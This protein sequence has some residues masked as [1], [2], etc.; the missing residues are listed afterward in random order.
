MTEDE[1]FMQA[2]FDDPAD[3]TPR[4]V[5]AD[6]LEEQ[7]DPRGQYLRAESKWAAPWRDGSAPADSPELRAAAAGLDPLW[8]LRLTRPPLGVCCS[9]LGLTGTG[10]RLTPDDLAAVGDKMNNPLPLVYRAFLLN[11][12]PALAGMKFRGNH[13]DTGRGMAF[14][15]FPVDPAK[16]TGGGSNRREFGW[17]NCTKSGAEACLQIGLFGKGGNCLLMV[18][19]GRV[20]EMWYY[21]LRPDRRRLVAD[22]LPAFL[23]TLRPE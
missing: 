2:I 17:W 23:A 21:T 12:N 15:F 4:L 7:D 11:H 9:H 20:G 19:E 6:W 13:P 5:Y 16:V 8:V 3:E 18:G 10:L 1:V 14:R 22:S